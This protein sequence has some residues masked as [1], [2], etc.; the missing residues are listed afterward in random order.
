MQVGAKLVGMVLAGVCGVTSALGHDFWL[1]PSSFA[2]KRG[3]VMKVGLRVGDEFPGEVVK[4][5]EQRLAMFVSAPEGR[6]ADAKPIV[7]R[8]GDSVAGL[9]R[10]EHNGT[11]VLAYRGNPVPLTLEAE[12]FESYLKEEGLESIIAKRAQRGESGKPG[13]ERYS[14]AAKA[15]VQVGKAT[16][17]ATTPVGLRLEITPDAET[18]ALK[19]GDRLSVT[20]TFEGKP[21]E[22]ALV[23]ARTPEDA[24]S[25]EL[26][27]TDASGKATFTI[28][29]AGMW[30][31]HSVHMVEA[32]KD[33][34]AD[35]ESTWSSLT[36]ELPK[37]GA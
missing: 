18:G 20:L 7:G 29:K 8:D 9:L 11:H 37:G 19:A 24:K 28:A 30:L 36:F 32:P 26:V 35:W 22:G 33:S 23:G 5:N 27:R 34:G 1:L 6:T 14:R 13:V 25:H 15:V 2:P 10:V 12:K 31:I 17:G 3:E 4:R 16:R 21:L